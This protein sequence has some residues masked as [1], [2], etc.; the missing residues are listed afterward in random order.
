MR[1]Q[2]EGICTAAVDSQTFIEG[3]RERER[4]KV[5]HLYLFLAATLETIRRRSKHSEELW[6]F[7][8]I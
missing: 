4:D 7:I 2:G 3:K 5:E 6:N 8:L 1:R